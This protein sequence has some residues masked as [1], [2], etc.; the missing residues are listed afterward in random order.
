MMKISI[1]TSKLNWSPA[2]H[3]FIRFLTPD[4]HALT[5][6]P[7]TICSI[8]SPSGKAQENALIFYVAARGG[9]TGRLSSSAAKIPDFSVPVLLEG[10]YGGVSGC[11]LTSYDRSVVVACGSGAGFSIPFIMSQLVSREGTAGHKM[12][13]IIATRNPAMTEWFEGA[14]VDFL[15]ENKLPMT[16]EGIEITIHVTGSSEVSLRPSG[17]DEKRIEGDDVQPK[18]D[19][20]RL[21]IQT[22]R[23]RPD[24][25]LIIQ[26]TI[27]EPGVSVG[28][29]VC[30]PESL[31]TVVQNE[32]ASGQ[33]R[34]L[35]GGSGAREIYLH[36]E[37][38]T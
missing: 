36:S 12:Q 19:A 20:R 7:F 5:S 3:M 13:V 8:P 26:R 18:D 37:H 32:A 16:L 33:K 29:A 15:E 24:I 10:P 25:Q 17:D 30:G 28:M 22:A 21:P 1:P 31:M 38:F 6:H 23:G 9:M 14:L 35:N 27:E 34:I 4:I 2:Q 11:P